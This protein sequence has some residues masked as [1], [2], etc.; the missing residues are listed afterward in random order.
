MKNLEGQIIT[1]TENKEDGG[2]HILQIYHIV[3]VA[4]L[5][6]FMEIKLS[7]LE[8]FRDLQSFRLISVF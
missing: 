5:E 2:K 8:S 6:A 4:R 3:P 7:R 1:L